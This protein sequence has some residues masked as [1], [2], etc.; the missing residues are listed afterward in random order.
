M[1]SIRSL[2]LSALKI[3]AFRIKVLLNRKSSR[4]SKSFTILSMLF[5]LFSSLLSRSSSTQRINDCRRMSRLRII[6]RQQQSFSTFL[7]HRC[8][9]R[10]STRFHRSSTRI[11]FFKSRSLCRT[12]SNAHVERFVNKSETF[13]RTISSS[14]R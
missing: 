1:M 7:I 13:T 12:S 2:M 8:R 10:S 4:S 6:N 9:R 11:F 14:I 3:S 5:F